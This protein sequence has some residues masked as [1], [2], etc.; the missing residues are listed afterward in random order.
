MS[1]ADPLTLTTP[2]ESQNRL[3]VMMVYGTRPEAIKMAPLIQAFRASVDFTPL[4]TVTGQH[5]SMLDQVNEVF[6]VTPDVDLDIHR[7]GQSLSDI[8]THSL[9]GIDKVLQEHRPDAVVVQGDTTTSF[10]VALAAGYA[11]IPLMHLEAGLRTNNRSSPFPEE[12]NRRLTTQLTTLHLAPT[13]HN[14]ANLLSE[15]VAAEDIV[16]TGNTVIDALTWAVA[17]RTPYG[18]AALE[19][20]DADDRP[21]LLVTAHR[22]ESWGP[23]MEGLGRA[24]ARIATAYPDLLIVFPIH[25]NPLVRRAV[26]PAVAGLRNVLVTEPLPYAAFCRLMARAWLILTDSGGV[27]EEGPSLGKPVLVFRDTTERP[28][29]AAAGTVAVVGTG[30]ENV[31]EAVQHLYDNPSA[32]RRMAM[33][34]NPYGDGQAAGRC[35]AAIAHHFGRGPRPV[36]FG[37]GPRAVPDPVVAPPDDARPCLADP[38]PAHR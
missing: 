37:P 19:D 2:L 28:E 14:R 29:A 26:L 22:R 21:V 10:A 25:L 24:L 32:Y 5:R 23:R 27:Q 34:V 15:N 16:V 17:R 13:H 18:S 8:T 35:V 33:A 9:R 38:S 1:L 12:I 3:R 31:V 7:P 20:L 6:G 30:E 11:R 36:E 4:V